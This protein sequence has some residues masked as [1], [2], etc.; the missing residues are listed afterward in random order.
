MKI[1]VE[2]FDEVVSSCPASS[3]FLKDLWQCLPGVQPS[4]LQWLDGYMTPYRNELCQGRF[5]LCCVTCC[6]EDAWCFPTARPGT[7]EGP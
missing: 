7:T 4:T 2:T 3:V 1:W 6:N 5:L